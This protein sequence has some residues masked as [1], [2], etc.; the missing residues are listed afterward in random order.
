MWP[1]LGR[2]LCMDGQ[3]GE[4][5]GIQKSTQARAESFSRPRGAALATHQDPVQD[6][7]VPNVGAPIH[8]LGEGCCS[9]HTA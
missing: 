6:T 3:K 5:A 9:P 4:A 7:E 1:G 2:A 8:H